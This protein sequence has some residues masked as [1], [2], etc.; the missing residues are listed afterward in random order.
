MKNIFF[1]STMILSITF[2]HGQTESLNKLD[3]NGKKDGKWAIYLD[4]KWKEVNDSTQSVYYHYTWYVHG[5]NTNPMGSFGKLILVPADNDLQKGKPK[6]LDGEYKWEDKNG[7]T[8]CI[9]ILKKG[10]PI[11]Y[12]DFYTTGQLQQYFDY[13]KKWQG[14]PHTYAMTINDKTG[15]PQYYYM[16]S[17]QYG[18]MGY[19]DR[20]ADSTTIKTLKTVGDSSFVTMFTYN[21]GKITGERDQIQIPKS[22]GKTIYIQ[23][24]HIIERYLNGQKR[25]EGDYYYGKKTG[26]W[27]SWDKDGKETKEK[28]SL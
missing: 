24:G 21:N 25:E 22:D 26:E 14:K 17:G 8:S 23:H 4:S 11:S 5:T 1:L 6:L 28:T 16:Y 7:R 15:K 18:W 19:G 27:K 12:K 3:S 2:A 9:L 20:D 10:E 13:T